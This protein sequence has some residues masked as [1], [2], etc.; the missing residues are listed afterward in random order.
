MGDAGYRG[1]SA[2]QDGRFRNK[3]TKLLKQSVP[4]SEVELTGIRI[5]TDFFSLLAPLLYPDSKPTRPFLPTS[6]K[7]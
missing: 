4:N 5:H 7:R 2:D 1:V 6:I 3:E